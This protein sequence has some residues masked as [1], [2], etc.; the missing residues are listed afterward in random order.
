MSELDGRSAM[1]TGGGAGIGLACVRALAEAGASVHVVDR[2][3]DA[4]RS[5]ADEVGGHAHVID[6]AQHE[7]FE[8]LPRDVD[9]LVNNAGIQHV[10]PV[11]DFPV[12]T[13]MLIQQVMLTGPFV[14]A[15]RFLPHMYEREWGRIVNISSVHGLRASPGKSAYV[16]AKHGLEGLSKT[17]ALEGAQHGV[18]S[19]CVNPGYVR[20]ALVE[21]QIDSQAAVHGMDRGDVVDDVLLH[22]SAI[23]RLIEPEEVAATVAWLCGPHAAY[24]SG[25]SLAM[26]GAWMAS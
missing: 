26:D 18:T 9:I 13:F 5:A 22:R 14:L 10:S 8:Q 23:K 21:N 2:E 16:A 24:I 3:A 20:T 17:L 6:L 19:N 15:Q 1:V 7:T 25:T 12:D 4:A 11:Q